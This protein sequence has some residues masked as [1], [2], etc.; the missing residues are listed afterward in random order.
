MTL[1]DPLILGP[2]IRKL[3]KILEYLWGSENSSTENTKMRKRNK[4]AIWDG[5]REINIED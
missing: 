2:G 1:Q 5:F 3:V 4:K